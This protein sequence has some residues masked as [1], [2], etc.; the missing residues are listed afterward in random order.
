MDEVDVPIPRF[1]EEFGGSY[2][3]K[4]IWSLTLN[5]VLVSWIRDRQGEVHVEV[6]FFEPLLLARKSGYNHQNWD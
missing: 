4:V 3:G 5:K 1:R 2:Q 6:S